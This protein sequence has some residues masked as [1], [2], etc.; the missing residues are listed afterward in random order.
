MKLVPKRLGPAVLGQVLLPVS[1][2]PWSGLHY[3]GFLSLA[4]SSCWPSYRPIPHWLWVLGLYPVLSPRAQKRCDFVLLEYWCSC[5]CPLKD[6]ER[7][8][9]FLLN[10][11]DIWYTQDT[12]RGADPA[13]CA[14]KIETKVAYQ[15][16]CEDIPG[17]SDSTII[18]FRYMVR[19]IARQFLLFYLVL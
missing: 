6:H 8:I 1:S 17:E 18:L 4:S 7:V 14:D 12:E 16:R 15:E 2:F 3:P 13:G 19:P 11:D 9:C 10:F 5:D